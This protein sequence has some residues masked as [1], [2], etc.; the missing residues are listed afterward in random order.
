MIYVIY[1]AG[2][3]VLGLL[4]LMGAALE[5]LVPPTKHLEDLD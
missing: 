3:V 2:I 4:Y 5:D 1:F